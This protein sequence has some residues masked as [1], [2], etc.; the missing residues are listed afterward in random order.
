MFTKSRRYQTEVL[1]I[2]EKESPCFTQQCQEK[3]ENLLNLKYY[4]LRF[5]IFNFGAAVN[6]IKHKTLPDTRNKLLI[7]QE[8]E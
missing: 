8:M 4:N 2:P 3:I 5:T 1:K 6:D 7:N